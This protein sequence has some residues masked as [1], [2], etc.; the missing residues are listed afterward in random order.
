MRYVLVDRLL[1]VDPGNRA[2]GCKNVT[3]TDEI[4]EHH[5]PGLPVMPGCLVLEALAQLSGLLATASLDF[6]VMPMLLMVDRAKFRHMVRPGDQLLLEADVVSLGEGAARLRTRALLA[7]AVDGP[8]AGEPRMVAEA[9]V[10]LALV[11]APPERSAQI[12]ARFDVLAGVPY[13]TL[14]ADVLGGAP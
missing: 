13:R 5:F 9:L 6:R 8:P 7:P 1:E 2:R 10:T 3:Q 12:R 11:P 14:A 4:F